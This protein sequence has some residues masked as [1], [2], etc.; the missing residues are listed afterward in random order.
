LEAETINLTSV[1]YRVSD[2]RLQSN[3]LGQTAVSRCKTLELFRDS[4]CHNLQGATD[5]VKSKSHYV[6]QPVRVE[7]L[8]G[9]LT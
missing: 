5:D 8:Q 9:L 3:I 4:L 7:S 6:S 2:I 1:V